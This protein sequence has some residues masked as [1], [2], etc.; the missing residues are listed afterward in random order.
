M[1]AKKKQK[2]K[3]KTIKSSNPREYKIPD[4]IFDTDK[5]V[6]NPSDLNDNFKKVYGVAFN[7]LSYLDTK[8]AERKINLV[9][10][11]FSKLKLP[12]AT[13]TY[14]SKEKKTIKGRFLEIY[15]Y[16][17]V[18]IKDGKIVIRSYTSDYE[19]LTGIS[20]SRFEISYSVDV[21][22]GQISILNLGPATISLSES[23]NETLFSIKAFTY[24]N[25]LFISEKF[26]KKKKVIYKERKEFSY[27]EIGVKSPKAKSDKEEADDRIIDLSKES[28]TY[29]YT[30]NDE[31]IK[32]S[33][34][35]KVDSFT[36]AGYFRRYKNGKVIWIEPT[37]V[38]PNKKSTNIKHKTYKI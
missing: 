18:Q 31:T 30:N 23:I 2:K 14:I 12:F 1:A 38:R 3:N 32:N 7:S 20:K 4:K 8:E 9:N 17:F 29:I 26:K 33:Y 5:I 10:M 13:F 25:L 11:D 24:S 28:Y 34:T 21:I 15:E 22:T 16:N 6:L 37:V 36:R 35:Y 19:I 27:K